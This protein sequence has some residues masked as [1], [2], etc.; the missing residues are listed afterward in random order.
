MRRNGE[1][2][3]ER[4]DN[5]TF[6]DIIIYKTNCA[7]SITRY[8]EKR[9]K[10]KEYWINKIKIMPEEPTLPIKTVVDNDKTFSRLKIKINREKWN[11]IKK[12]VNKEG[13]TPSIVIL[14]AYT[15]VLRRW[16]INKDF[17]IN[18][19]VMERSINNK[20]FDDIIGDFTTVDILDIKNNNLTFLEKSK[21]IQETFLSNIEHNSFS[22]I[23]VLRELSRV[24]GKDIIIPY[25]FTST[26]GVDIDTSKDF[27]RKGGLFN[28]S[29]IIYGISQTPQVLIDC[30]VIENYKFLEINWDYRKGYFQKYVVE[31]MFNSFSNIVNNISKYLSDKDNSFNAPISNYVINRRIELNSNIRN[32]P[33]KMLYDGFLYNLENLPDSPAVINKGNSYSYYELG[34]YVSSLYEKMKEKNVKYKDYVVILEKRGIWQIATVLASL[35]LGARFIPLDNKQPIKRINKILNN[36]GNPLIIID[37]S[38]QIDSNNFININE[39]DIQNN[40][41]V[42]NPIGEIDD[43]AYTIYTSGSTG[44]PKGVNI[45][46]NSVMN[47]IYDVN[48]IINVKSDDVFFMISKLSFDLS[49]YDI[50]GCFE[51]GARLVVPSDD[52]NPNEHLQLIKEHSIT[53]WNSVPSIL[54]MFFN[55]I[56]ENSIDNILSIK[57]VL[58]SGDK[59]PKEMPEEIRKKFKNPIALS[60]GGA[61]E[62]AI[63]SIYYNIEKYDDDKNIPYGIPLANQKIFVLD[64]NLFPCPNWTE[65]EICIS[66]VGLA[67]GYEGDLKLSGEKFVWNKNSKERVYLTG[68]IGFYNNE[69]VVEICGRKDNQIKIN[70]NRIELGEI[71]NTILKLPYVK[72][73]IVLAKDFKNNIKKLIAFV[74][75][76]NNNKE[77]I[78]VNTILSD[79]IINI[80]NNALMELDKLNREQLSEWINSAN[81]VAVIEMLY[82]LW[83]IGLFVKKG[84]LYSLTKIHEIIKEKEEFHKTVNKM[85]KALINE[86]YLSKKEEKYYLVKD[87]HIDKIRFDAWKK[88]KNIEQRVNYSKIFCDYFRESCDYILEQLRGDKNSIDLFFP[89]GSTEVALAA[90]QN[91]I[92]NKTLNKIVSKIVSSYI[93]ND[94]KKGNTIEILEIGAGVGGTTKDVVE[95]LI[96]EN[97]EYYF[98][99]ISKY[100]IN[101][102]KK[103]YTDKKFMKYE[104]FDINKDVIEEKFNTKFDIIISANVLHNAIN[105]D[106]TLKR[107]YQNLNDNGILIIIDATKE[108]NSLLVSLELKGG[109]GNFTDLRKSSDAFFYNRDQ[110]IDSLESSG[111]KIFNIY[112]SEND[113]LSMMGQSV[114][115]ASKHEKDNIVNYK[116]SDINE[117]IESQLPKHMIPDKIVKIDFI[118]LNLNGKIDKK[119]LL[120]TI[121]GDID[122]TNNKREIRKA[123]TSLEKSIMEI[124]ESTIGIKG[125]SIDDNFYVIG[126]DSLLIAQVVT[127]MKKSIPEISNYNWDEIMKLA[128]DNSTISGIANAIEAISKKEV[129]KRNHTIKENYLNIY[130]ESC[131]SNVVQAY[132][133]AGTGRLVDYEKIIKHLLKLNKSEYNKKILGFTYGDEREY[134]SI[135]EKQLI[136]KLAEKYA[137]K[138]I[139]LDAAKYELV[140]YCIGGFI[141]LETAKILMENGKKVSKVIL[142]SS[143]LCLHNIDN[144]LLIEY[145][146]GNVLGADMGKIGINNSNNKLRNALF[147][148]TN[149]QGKNIENGDL[150]NLNEEFAQYGKIFKNLSELNHGQRLN[151]IYNCMGNKNF[152]GE[153][154]TIA[155]LNILYNVF[156][157]SF[158]GMINYYPHVYTGETIVLNPEIEIST[159][160]PTFKS[161]IDWNDV[162]WGE[163]NIYNIPGSHES[164]IDKDHIKNILPFLIKEW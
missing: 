119:G 118:P 9:I 111:F 145:A 139:E 164:C 135:E 46:H 144:Q 73:S 102:A 137:N 20:I 72:E 138:L 79:F 146:Y 31:D 58:L 94:R 41:S 6:R 85:L 61:T 120:N 17:C 154:S 65:G 34:L 157:H 161:D 149:E 71:E 148:I 124:W 88:L 115:L 134:V 107:L 48:R 33:K 143:H 100:F 160:Y 16:S 90:Y 162:I 35:L 57:S 53:I 152:N 96:D 84:T 68:D 81:D 4:K 91:N 104:L 13:L 127:K 125:I 151:L 114:I 50:F 129:K 27:N 70:G 87:I 128:L 141:A 123:K 109:L 1:S 117:F 105:I 14:T 153:E 95:G 11:D 66:G 142:I 60:L 108:L 159:F 25:V 69:G 63:W 126:G 140:G 150:I 54:R 5:I 18:M 56:K 133:H 44:E 30:Q 80:D 52:I 83:K 98:T 106:E 110:W 26:L 156:E 131:K 158:K 59:I 12:I 112:P 38:N 39:I 76:D 47:T 51:V 103:E 32:F 64:K 8:K 43:I 22:G 101:N 74:I 28:Q 89:Q 99:D 62:A 97:I 36:L 78:K 163:L 15:E 55:E 24:R 42:F 23:E 29:Q 93:K 10:D 82:S 45:T 75:L 37:T 122:E 49:I 40:I 7:K 92:F 86:G 147:S 19:T 3:D 130:N 113:S 67:T 132:F 116:L 2:E 121:N 136:Y 77:N 155:M 21:L